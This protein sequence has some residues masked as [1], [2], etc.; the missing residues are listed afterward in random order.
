[1]PHSSW[2][3]HSTSSEISHS[4]ATSYKK[5]VEMGPLEAADRCCI[6]SVAAP[7]E[8]FGDDAGKKYIML[9]ARSLR[10]WLLKTMLQG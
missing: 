7:L 6:A 1:M 4:R 9:A 5:S 8:T 2:I 10:S 3:S